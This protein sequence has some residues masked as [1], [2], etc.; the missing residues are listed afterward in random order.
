MSSLLLDVRYGLRMLAKHPGF[1][2]VAVLT[3]ALGMGATTAMFSVIEC[4]VLDPFPFP[5]SRRITI[6]TAHNPRWGDDNGFGWFSGSELLE[7]QK[8]NHIFEEVFGQSMQN[9]LLTGYGEPLRL[10][11]SPVTSNYFR[12][13]GRPALIGRPLVPSDA[14]AGAPP[15]AVLCYDVWRSKFNGDLSIVGRTVTLN[16]QLTTIVGVMPRR[17]KTF[18]PDVWVPAPASESKPP[19]QQMHFVLFGR[20]KKEVSIEQEKAE[21][22]VL[23]KRFAKLYPKDHPKDTMIGIELMI[24]GGMEKLQRTLY[25]LL[26]AVCLLQL[27][28]CVNVANLL[29]ARA[30]TREKEIAIR[31]S[32]GATAGRL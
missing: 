16:H 11:G 17:F 22:E 2:I 8:Q 30:T 32:L 9:V 27:I 31:S 1:T 28:A 4:A 20:L 3:L 29:L 25:F 24:K 18:A 10:N 15:V 6:M 21:V 5:D 14:N 19:E 12:G 26:G 23:S 13:L 7:Y